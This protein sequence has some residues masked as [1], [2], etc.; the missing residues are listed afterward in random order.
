MIVQFDAHADLRDSYNNEKY[1]HASAIRRCLDYDNVSL[2]SLGK[3][4][5]KR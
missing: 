2:L 5:I 3:E 4:Y 1:P